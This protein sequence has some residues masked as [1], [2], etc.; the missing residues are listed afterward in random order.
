M[1][2]KFM[3]NGYYQFE[4]GRV[5]AIEDDCE[6][7]PLKYALNE[8]NGLLAIGGNLSSARLLNAY[9]QGIFPWFNA[10][11]P[12]MWYST[13][14][15]MVLFPNEL[16]ISK[17][18]AKT[19]KNNTFETRINT[20]FKAVITGCSLSLRGGQTG[21]ENNTKNNTWISPD[22]IAAYCDLH[23]QGYAVSAETFPSL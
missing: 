2:K 20:A 9:R 5:A 12:I 18:L 3:S 22:M 16:K 8:P 19:L 13:N 15:R 17:S 4:T 14:P 23:A 1:T 21:T 11:D 7:P 6:F 10:G